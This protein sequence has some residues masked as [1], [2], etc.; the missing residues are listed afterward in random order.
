MIVFSITNGTNSEKI[1][2]EQDVIII[3]RS[4]KDADVFI[5]DNQV[6][7]KHCKVFKVNSHWYIED[8]GSTNGTYYNNNKLEF[9]KKERFTSSLNEIVVG[10]SQIQ[11]QL[12][13]ED[14]NNT[15]FASNDETIFATPI[16][17]ETIFETKN[18][19]HINMEVNT[20][21][22]KDEVKKF[23]LVG[24]SDEVKGKYIV[25]DFTNTTNV[26]YS[27]IFFIYDGGYVLIENKSD[28]TIKVDAKNING[29][30][31]LLDNISVII[32][33]HQ[34]IFSIYLPSDATI[35]SSL[36]NLLDNVQKQEIDIE[37]NNLDLAQKE[38]K[39]NKNKMLLAIA[40]VSIILIGI[41]LFLNTSK[42][43]EAI[44]DINVKDNIG[45]HLPSVRVEEIGYR[46][47]DFQAELAGNLK[48]IKEKLYKVKVTARIEKIY[49]SEGDKVK[50][51]TLLSK[52]ESQ[53]IKVKLDKAIYDLEKAKYDISKAKANIKMAKA[54]LKK[55]RLQATK[56]E[57]ERK[58][59]L[60]KKGI[61][62]QSE[63]DNSLKVYRNMQEQYQIAQSE[64][65]FKR[66][67]LNNNILNVKSMKS[68][69]DSI[70]LELKDY[71]IY[72][73]F[74][75]VVE[76]IDFKEGEVITANTIFFKIVNL[77][78]LILEVD[79][80][81]QYRNLLAVNSKVKI[82]ISNKN[83]IGDLYY[84]STSADQK[85]RTFKV[86]IWLD[87]SDS[88]LYSGLNANVLFKENDKKKY[89]I[90]QNKSIQK[91]DNKKSYI[92]TIIDSRVEKVFVDI[93]KSLDGK[94]A[95][96]AKIDKKSKIVIEG[97]ENIVSNQKVNI[98][99]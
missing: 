37:D 32:Q 96:N 23:Y 99:K 74:N 84:I 93:I 2:F 72:S 97:F 90:C 55:D 91:D 60:F 46:T 39:I 40:I 42:D 44:L 88:K 10:S 57:Y 86:K 78:K 62:S 92:Y 5:D 63:L 48:P 81:K 64:V 59:N 67:E 35:Q 21:I 79:V 31:V 1:E 94:S 68:N 43:K 19:E 76:S 11:I 7:R 6:S 83:Y 9:M 47:L 49:K 77:D 61:A 69:I 70:E 20:H 73:D 65:E 34:F 3:G 71:E 30:T 56:S 25:L 26:N 24:H 89:F 75:G 85:T 54:K 33:K 38:I 14:D 22:I 41:F 52:L 80:A 95:I 53:N 87:N 66:L 16:S 50:K 45:V 82:S 13:E 98:I 29:K 36:I 8:L 17:D 4:D 27:D 12:E 28:F 18:N 51:G 15:V 58:K